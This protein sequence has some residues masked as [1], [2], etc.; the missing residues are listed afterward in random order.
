MTCISLGST[1]PIRT[2]QL[3]LLFSI[4][5]AL[6]AC[7]SDSSSDD[8]RAA[9]TDFI[10]QP[11][12]ASDDADVLIDDSIAFA[13]LPIAARSTVIGDVLVSGSDDRTLYTFAADEPGQS[14]CYDSCAAAWPPIPAS[15]DAETGDFS[16]VNRRDD[17]LQWS[18]KV[19]AAVPLRWR[20]RSGRYP[21]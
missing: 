21:R 20:L 17:S 5:L 4:L 16:T 18:F 10:A 14:T 3:S 2:F 12:V 9:S 13:E 7:G 1:R 8:A 6:G 15:E 11:G 19:A